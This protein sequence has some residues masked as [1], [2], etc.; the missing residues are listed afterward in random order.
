MLNNL[1]LEMVQGG[2]RF[3]LNGGFDIAISW[4]ACLVIYA[5]THIGS[6]IYRFLPKKR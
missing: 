1:S 6:K 4:G 3:A 5:V 2:F